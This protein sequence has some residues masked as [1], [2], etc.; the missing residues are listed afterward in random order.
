MPISIPIP[1]EP[2]DAEK[3]SKI[4]EDPAEPRYSD[5]RARSP[6]HPGT[7]HG[8][9]LLPPKVR[10]ALCSAILAGATPKQIHDDFGIDR[11]TYSRYR[12]LLRDYASD[13]FTARTE[14]RRNQIERDIQWA[15]GVAKEGVQ[16]A[17][18]AREPVLN[19]DGQVVTRL[20]PETGENEI[21]YSEKPDSR[22]MSMFLKDAHDAIDQWGDLHELTGKGADRRN[23]RI[24][25]N[26]DLESRQTLQTQ[27]L[28]H[29]KSNGGLLNTGPLQV[30]VIPKLPGVEQ[31]PA[32]TA[33]KA[34][35][36]ASSSS[37]PVVDA[38]FSDS[39]E[40]DGS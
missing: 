20:N 25:Q 9:K 12:Q 24:M 35:P 3:I 22:A 4:L 15:L 40:D 39:P 33:P 38:E 17:Q 8:M 36:P 26:K 10:N 34:E 23:A 27:Q 21:V 28:E 19:K 31:Y 2:G 7:R 13:L 29:Q 30:F 16:M 37:L 5:G 11:R 14:G 6:H 1:H 18:K 32:L